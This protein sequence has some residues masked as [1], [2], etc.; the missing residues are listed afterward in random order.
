MNDKYGEEQLSHPQAS[1]V[2]MRLAK[3]IATKMANLEVDLSAYVIR[4]LPSLSCRS[5]WDISE[6]KLRPNRTI[7]LKQ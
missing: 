7:Y 5:R 1:M 4:H 3:T 6:I 2:L